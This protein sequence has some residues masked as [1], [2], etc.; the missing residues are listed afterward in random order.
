MTVYDLRPLVQS[1]Q[2]IVASHRLG[3]DG[4]YRRWNWPDTEGK[5]E[6]GLNP[7]GVAD[8]ANILYTINAFPSAPEERADWINVLR[9]LQSEKDGMFYESTHHEIHTTAHCI[10]ALELF[11]ARPQHPL[12]ALAPYRVISAMRHYLDQLNWRGQP[13]A[14]S[15]RGAG[16]YAALT[17]AGEVSLEWKEA[18]FAWLLNNTDPATGLVRKGCIGP[19]STQ[20]GDTLFPHLAGT[21]HYLFN[22]E[23]DHQPLQYPAALV[24]TCLELFAH[25]TFPIGGRISFSEIDWTYCLNR[26]LR[27]SHHRTDEARAALE[28]FAGEYFPY[29]LSLDPKTDDGLND[30]HSLFGALCCVAELQA[31]LPG[32]V[33][34]EKPLRLVLDRR[35]FI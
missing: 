5:R 25:R 31:A 13:W 26:A 4:A 12:K 24:D 20:F 22:Q 18:Y 28:K 17:L 29:L 14:Q 33:R 19:I 27:Q 2:E 11:D 10:A 6:L 1:V 9:G 3:P 30:L 21:F 34:T 35:P 8:A 32:V 23:S 15:H 7:Y 16:L